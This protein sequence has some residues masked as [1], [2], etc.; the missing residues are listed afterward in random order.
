LTR[1]AVAALACALVL[2]G[3]GGA[4][5]TEDDV[6]DAVPA[7][8]RAYVHIDTDSADWKRARE[9]LRRLPALEGTVIDL[10]G[11][12][13][14]PPK[15]GETGIVTLPGAKPVV[16]RPDDERVARPLAE[17][18]AYVDLL[19]GL[20]D[21]RFVHG[22]LARGAL[23]P[24]RSFDPSVTAAAAAAD[25]DGDLM[26]IRLRTA[27][28]APVGPCSGGH[29]EEDLLE[30]ADPDA[31]VYLEIPS[32]ACGLRTLSARA[33]GVGAWLGRFARAAR[34]RGD[35]SI[36]EELLP[37]LKSRGALVA[38]PGE[39]APTITLI[40]DPVDEQQALDL[41]ARLQP[42]FIHL[43]GSEE[44]G[45]APSFGAAEVGGVT[46]ATAQLAPGLELS[47]AAWDDRLVVSTSLDGIAAARRADGLPGTDAFEA[48]LGDRPSEPSALLFL[49]LNQLLALGEQAGLAEDP[50]YLAVRDDLQ[51]LRA[52]GAVLSREE[53]FT[54]AE[55][56]FQIP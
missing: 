37:L 2:A 31:A 10:L 39:R 23:A 46:A 55:L 34:R 28:D 27:H 51:K 45:Q 17:L 43:L 3:C 1:A 40:V 50:R 33:D 21:Q 13:A 42:A 49:D 12:V 32:I 20:P 4:G 5:V 18:P 7:N 6:V 22:Y 54:T 52:A 29:G 38:T 56:T 53:K 19:D 26:R 16:M 24:L 8:A 30:M 48:V 36:E 9:A 41:L 11:R 25:V 15:A 44:L 35:V 47:Y 14:E